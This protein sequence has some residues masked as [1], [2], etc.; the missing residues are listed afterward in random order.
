MGAPCFRRHYI[1]SS[2]ETIIFEMEKIALEVVLSIQLVC[3]KNVTG[4]DYHGDFDELRPLEKVEGNTKFKR[5][6]TN[7]CGKCKDAICLPTSCPPE[8]SC[9]IFDQ[10]DRSEKCPLTSQE[11]P[12]EDLPEL[13]NFFDIISNLVFFTNERA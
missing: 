8:A 2:E 11:I 12:L 13:N 6:L 4:D 10:L 1:V 7:T 3:P 9:E 5:R